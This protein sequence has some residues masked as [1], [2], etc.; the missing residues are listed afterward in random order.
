M[1]EVT[2]ES[3]ES[4]LKSDAELAATVVELTDTSGGCGASYFAVIVSEK[5]EGLKL[6][7][8]H[9]LVNNALADELKIIHAFQMKTVTP[10]EYEKLKQS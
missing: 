6:L 3:I 2:V 9:R 7:Q 8:R 10:T 1:A 5:F 4:K